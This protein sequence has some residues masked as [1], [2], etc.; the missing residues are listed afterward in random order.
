[1][2]D[3]LR[4]HNIREYHVGKHL[5]NCMGTH[6]RGLW[7][8]YYQSSLIFCCIWMIALSLFCQKLVMCSDQTDKV[9]NIQKSTLQA[10]LVH[11]FSIHTRNLSPSCILEKHQFTLG[12]AFWQHICRPYSLVLR[13]QRRNDLHILIYFLPFTAGLQYISAF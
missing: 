8:Y 7:Y 11:S 13:R 9:Q 3:L 1:M 6:A 5:P 10:N 4:E 12:H 2:L